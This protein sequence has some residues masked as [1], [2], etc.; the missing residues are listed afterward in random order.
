VGLASAVL[1]DAVI[2]R[3]VLVPSVMLLLGRANWWLP[4]WL[5][6]LLPHLNVEGSSAGSAP[7]RDLLDR[8]P[9]PVRV[10]EEH[11]LPPRELLDVRHV[12]ATPGQFGSRVGGA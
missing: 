3:A 12:H 4:G 11:E 1:L 10:A 6:R 5:D 7:G 9:V 8:P 2:V